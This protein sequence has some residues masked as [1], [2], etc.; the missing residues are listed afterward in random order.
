[1]NAF[2]NGVDNINNI[3]YHVQDEFFGIS[4]FSSETK[5]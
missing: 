1:M 5:E 3:C 2:S 4:K